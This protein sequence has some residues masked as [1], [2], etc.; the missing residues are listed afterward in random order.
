MRV[1]G[2]VRREDLSSSLH[3][4]SEAIVMT[5]YPTQPFA[6]LDFFD[7]LYDFII[8]FDDLVGKARFVGS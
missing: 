8:R 1:V 2:V 4:C 6:A 5:H 3:L 7:V